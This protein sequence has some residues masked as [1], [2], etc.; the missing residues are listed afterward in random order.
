M[1]TAHLPEAAMRG[2]ADQL[3]LKI[4]SIGG[5]SEYR[6]T[7]VSKLMFRVS[8]LMFRGDA[9]RCSDFVRGY[10]VAKGRILL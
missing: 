3:D 4:E 5:S 2:L 7:W 6:I 10:A 9:D 8:K 1:S